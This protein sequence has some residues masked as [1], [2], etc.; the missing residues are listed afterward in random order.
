MLA[1]AY[2]LSAF[3]ELAL[4]AAPAAAVQRL[5]AS[6]RRRPTPAMPRPTVPRRTAGSYAPA[7]GSVI[8]TVVPWPGTLATAI[9]PPFS[10][11]FRLAIV[12]PRPVPVA[13]VEK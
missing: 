13:L 2:L 8:V 10:S 5:A 3:V 1:Y 9:V 12:R 7:T 6:S 11:M 4:D